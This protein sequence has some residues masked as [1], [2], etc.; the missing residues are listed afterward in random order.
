VELAQS[1][2]KKTR[3][4]GELRVLLSVLLPLCFGLSTEETA[5]VVGRSPRWVT[6]ARNAYIR[7]PDRSKESVPQPRNR[8]AMSLEEEEAFLAPFFAQ[9]KEG[10][11]LVVGSLHQALEEPLGRKVA[12]ATAYN[13]LHRHGWRQR[14]PDKNRPA[15]APHR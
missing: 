5:R 1:R 3:D 8:A 2:I 14:T 11:L 13:L 7:C 6:Q 10:R 9:A 4:A 12:L 15:P